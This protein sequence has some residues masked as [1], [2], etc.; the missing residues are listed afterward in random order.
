L[1]LECYSKFS[2]KQRE[3]E[4]LHADAEDIALLEAIQDKARSKEKA[5]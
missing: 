5:H 2:Q 4:R 3:E 1:A